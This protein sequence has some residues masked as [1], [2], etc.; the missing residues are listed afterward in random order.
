MNRLKIKSGD[1]I[2]YSGNSVLSDAINVL[3][4]GVPRISASHVGITCRVGTEM[5]VFEALMVSSRPCAITGDTGPGVIASKIDTPKLSPG[6]VYRYPLYRPLYAHEKDRLEHFL[7]SR[8]GTPYDKY[9]AIGSGGILTRFFTGRLR[10]ESDQSLFC[11]E[12]AAQALSEIGLFSTGNFSNWA[13]NALLRRGRWRG[14]F[15]RPIRVK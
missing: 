7:L 9:G 13:P 2:A 14:V 1:V 4:L 5:F 3:S 15:E 11:S 12:L 6:R 8:L 10:R